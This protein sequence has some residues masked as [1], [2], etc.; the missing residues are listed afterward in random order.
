MLT[1]PTEQAFIAALERHRDG[2]GRH[3]AYL[4]RSPAD[5]EDALQD[6]LLRAWRYRRSL[7]ADD[8]R[9]WLYRIATNACRDLQTRR[10]PPCSSLEDEPSEPAAPRDQLPEVQA[11]ERETVEHALLAALRYLPPR[12]HT[13]FVLRDLLCCS[14]R[15]TAAA[16]SISVPAANSAVQ[17]ARTALRTRLDR[18]SVDWPALSAPA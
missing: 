10:D 1:D 16:L 7:T 13:A 18:D 17:R 3:C 14:S 8:P 9:P 2:L 11:L 15:E 4:L 12:Q 6:T 5:A